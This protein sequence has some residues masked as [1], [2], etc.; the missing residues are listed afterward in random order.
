MPAVALTAT[1]YMA[2]TLTATTRATSAAQTL[3]C[4]AA[5]ATKACMAKTLTSATRATG[6]TGGGVYGESYSGYGVYGWSNSSYGVYGRNNTSGNFGHLGSSSYGVYG[7]NSNGNKGYIGIA[8]GGVEGRSDSGFG[9]YGWSNSGYGVYGYSS[10]SYAG[11]FSGNVYATGSMS[12]DVMIDRTP[13]PKDLATA[14][15]A[16]MSMER[17]PDG[18]YEEN[19]KEKQLD[20]SKLSAFIKSKDG[21]RDL[22]ATVSCLNEVVKDLIR[23]N[24]ELK[25]QLDALEKNQK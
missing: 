24:Q 9:V 16:V 6:L 10:S 8:G 1:A 19:N 20:H 14:Y 18:Q 4:M 25:K 2:K 13:Y 23:E 17:L 5:A 15:Q 3:A 21:N 12:A 11:Y 7:E 22:S